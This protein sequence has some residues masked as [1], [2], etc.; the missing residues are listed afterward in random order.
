[1]N[2]E[3]Q[4]WAFGLVWILNEEILGEFWVLWDILDDLG[5]KSES[6]RA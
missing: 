3:I 1:M 2:L 6:G 5:M 4:R